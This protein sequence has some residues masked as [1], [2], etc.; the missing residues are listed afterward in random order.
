VKLSKIDLSGAKT[1]GKLADETNQLIY[2]FVT[3]P[4]KDLVIEFDYLT[5]TTS[6][7]LESTTGLL[8]FSEDFRIDAVVKIYNEDRDKDLLVWTDNRNAPRIINIARAKTYGAD[9]FV[10]ADIS[11]SK[12]PP[13]DQPTITLVDTGDEENNIE[14]K[15]LRFSY[16]YKYLDNQLSAMAPFTEVAFEADEFEFDYATSTNKSMLNKFN[17]VDVEFNTGDE[18]VVEVELLVKDSGSNTV[19]IIET[20]NKADEGWGDNTNQTFRY[21][22]TKRKKALP[23]SELLKLFDN[24]PKK[25]KA[26]DL[27][28]D[29]LCFSNYTENFNIVDNLGN[30]IGF[31]F[32]LSVDSQ[33]IVEGDAT[34][35][36]KSNRDYEVGIVYIESAT[37]KMTT[38]FT[39]Q[40]NDAHV[41]ASASTSD[42]TLRL[43][44]SHR[45]PVGFDKYRIFIKQNK[46]AY[47]IIT[48]SLFYR[49]GVY[50]WVKLEGND[51]DKIAE[52]DFLVVKSDSREV[53]NT[54]VRTRVLEIK[55]QPQNFLETDDS[56]TTLEQEP[57]VYMRIRPDEYRLN[58]DDF[59]EIDYETFQSSYDNNPILNEANNIERAVFYGDTLDDLTS[60]EGTGFS[61]GSDIRY[62]VEIITTGAT[63][64]FR[65]SDDDGMSWSAN[66]AITGA[67]QALN[68]G[69]TV[70]FGATTGHSLADN[71]VI[72]AKAQ[73]DDGYGTDE[74]SNAY[75]IAKGPDG[76]II[77]AGT[78]ITI[79]YDEYN[80]A[81]QF[82]ERTYV[83]STNYSDLEEFCYRQGVVDDLIADG[84][85]EERIW[86]R[87][88]VVEKVFNFGEDA[89]LDRIDSALSP[90]TGTKN[91]IIKS[92]GTKN[93]PF[94]NTVRVRGGIFLRKLNNNIV[95]ETDPAEIN[96]DQFQEI[97]KTYDI[98]TVNRFHLGGG[99]SDLSQALGTS[100]VLNLPFFNCISWGNGF[101]SAKI[102]DSFLGLYL[103]QD[104]RPSTFVEEYAENVRFADMTYSGP[105]IENTGV[106]QLSSFN[107]SQSNFK[108]DLEKKWGSVQRIYG[109]DTD[110]VVF[111]EDKVSKVLFGKR[112]LYN[113]D[114]TAN[115]ASIDDVL[116]QQVPYAGDFG[117]ARNPE[118]FA[119]DG[120]NM[121]YTDAKRGAVLRLGLNGNT[122]ISKA[123]MDNYFLELFKEQPNS[124][125]LGGYD[126]YYDQ[127]VFHSLG[128]T[129][130]LNPAF[131]TLTFDEDIDGWTSFHSFQPED[132]LGMNNRLFTW[133]DGE[134]YEHHREDATRNEYYGTVYP[135]QISVVVN[136]NPSVI[137]I[138]KALKIEGTTAWD[139]DIDAYLTGTANPISGSVAQTEF[140][141]REGM[142]Y[143]Y[144]RRNESSSH[145]D[146]KSTYGVGIVTGIVGSTLIITG[147][148]TSLSVGDTVQFFDPNDVNPSLTSAGTVSQIDRV[149]GGVE[150]VLSSAAGISVG[151]FISGV[152]SARIEGG[153][154]RGYTIRLDL[155]A[156]SEDKLELFAINS[157]VNMAF[158][159]NP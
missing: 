19:F 15:L 142:W 93:N 16:R 9:G 33:A 29:L 37:G 47:D 116:G 134:L 148:N 149:A 117:I 130:Q 20:F 11:L 92:L 100:A 34:K 107:L 74:G 94:D 88:G 39:S 68:N 111:Q 31:D 118:S 99:G 150:L 84:I 121:Y 73:S 64:E 106:N 80:E 123:G 8:N 7:L 69:V 59:E 57:G 24:V 21:K 22:N 96:S 83:A 89:L 158:P 13:S 52:G 139:V 27:I 151:D 67:A 32:S 6:I 45:A 87:V 3:S 55:T 28:G 115:V 122:R 119:V 126:P 98:D 132:I 85:A 26:M 36:V 129:F 30:K 154:L 42:N 135:S 58:E 70:T 78:R 153:G 156:T 95:F 133:K 4:T 147:D 2:W 43:E 23:E 35:S 144:A 75:W 76:D 18:R 108:D 40:G 46:G 65:W 79:R 12:A 131:T 97:G 90:T 141:L 136:E 157:E 62:L 110:V 140:N 120:F 44:I 41:P 105:Y 61:G 63:D 155:E 10:E 103:G 114:G 72:P 127:Y 113:T 159:N 14:D 38:V 138:L 54:L 60:N 143:A 49:D 137:K 56:I 81:T 145:L 125:K 101:E 17:G 124:L 146:S 102:R 53:L 104:T 50:S 152:K 86:F 1:I 25:A 109:R 128:G 5:S 71:W 82:V 91:L 51:Q 66:T 48:P 77:E 112:L